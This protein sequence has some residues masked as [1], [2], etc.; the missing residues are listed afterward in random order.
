MRISLTMC[1]IRL[2]LRTPQQP[3]LTI[4]IILFVCG[5]HELS[6]IPQLRLR[7]LQIRLFLQQFWKVQSFKVFNCRI[8]NCK[9]DKR[10]LA[11]MRIPRQIWFRPVAESAYKA[12]NAHFDLVMYRCAV[13]FVDLVVTMRV[14]RISIISHTLYCSF[15]N[16]SQSE[17]KKV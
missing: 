6:W 14:S 10:K 15:A 5:F 3:N 4:H 17:L 12:H 1:E 2:Q 8:Q 13:F 9:E 16:V 7:I 11:M